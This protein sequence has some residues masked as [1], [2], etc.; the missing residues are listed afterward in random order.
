MD[1]MLVIPTLCGNNGARYCSRVWGV[2][3]VLKGN[4][5]TRSGYRARSTTIQ[6][7]SMR[8]GSRHRVPPLGKYDDAIAD[9]NQALQIDT[10]ARAIYNARGAALFQKGGVKSAIADYNKAIELDPT[11]RTPMSIGGRPMFK[12]QFGLAIADF[13]AVVKLAPND[14]RG[15]IN[16]G[17]ALASKGELDRRRQRLR[18][19]G[20]PRSQKLGS[21]H[22]PR[23]GEAAPRRPRALARR[24]RQGGRAQCQG[25]RSLH[26]SRVDPQRPGLDPKRRGK[27][28]KVRQ[29]CGRMRRRC[30][31][32][33]KSALN[34]IAMQLRW[35]LAACT[36][37]SASPQIAFRSSSVRPS[38]FLLVAENIV[39]QRYQVTSGN[40]TEPGCRL[41]HS[42]HFRLNSSERSALAT[43]GSQFGS[44]FARAALRGRCTGRRFSRRGL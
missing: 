13:D 4:L 25:E 44:G 11:I 30:H 9:F 33:Q 19:G 3:K 17:D 31:Y 43:N 34:A 1:S 5:K 26:K 40:R 7:S 6:T 32:E 41:P 15:Y 21:L 35:S 37:T 29:G 36:S 20:W 10:R 2:G 23:R 22:P 8:S 39:F 16:R 28:R 38:K 12:T 27:V 18:C 14:R 24:S 42:Y